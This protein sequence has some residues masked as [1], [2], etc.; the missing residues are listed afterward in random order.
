M[1][2][3]LRNF[4]IVDIVH[5]LCMTDPNPPKTEQQKPL[6]YS[7]E[8][9][10]IDK[11][12]CALV[13]PVE[14][15]HSPP[16]PQASLGYE[17]KK[18]SGMRQGNMPWFVLN[19]IILWWLNTCVTSLLYE[20]SLWFLWA[21]IIQRCMLCPKYINQQTFYMLLYSS[22]LGLFSDEDAS[23]FLRHIF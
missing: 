16:S 12:I 14:T 5:N 8:Y 1:Y 7:K 19:S 6:Q 3:Y 13:G 9:L 4:C 20:L 17:H 2:W 21:E 10:C 15:S 11:Y 23:N 18:A 22:N